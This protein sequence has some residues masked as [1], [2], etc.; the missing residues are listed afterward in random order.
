MSTFAAVGSIFP[1]EEMQLRIRTQI[2]IHISSLLLKTFAAVGSIFPS[3]EGGHGFDTDLWDQRGEIYYHL[4]P[5]IPIQIYSHRK[6]HMYWK[7]L[8]KVKLLSF[9]SHQEGG[10]FSIKTSTTL[11]TAETKFKVTFSNQLNT[12]W[13]RPY[14]VVH[15]N[16]FLNYFIFEFN[17]VLLYTWIRKEKDP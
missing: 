11:K 13:I 16:S 10:V 2:Q 8:L 6:D 7:V 1:S 3:E 12:F 17:Y 5:F 9:L 14:L 4:F 15:E